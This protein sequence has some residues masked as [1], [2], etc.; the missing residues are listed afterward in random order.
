M[1]VVIFLMDY[2]LYLILVLVGKVV[3]LLFLFSCRYIIN[4]YCRFQLKCTRVSWFATKP[5]MWINK[6]MFVL[7]I[8]KNTKQ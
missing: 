6:I 7:L 4:V 8:I 2:I 5:K 3:K 1:V